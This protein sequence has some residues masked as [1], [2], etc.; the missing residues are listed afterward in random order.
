MAARDKNADLWHGGIVAYTIDG[1]V[2]RLD[3]ISEA[4][5]NYEANTNVRFVRR[6]LHEDYVRF[7]LDA[8]SPYFSDSI[9]RDGGEQTI[10]I[11]ST[12]VG[13]YY[14]EIGH[15]LGLIHEQKRN[16]RDSFVTIHW[17]NI[18]E[19]DHDQ[20]E[21][22]EESANSADYDFR[23][24]MHYP[25][26]KDGVVQ[27]EAVGG[28]PAPGMIGRLAA[29]T[30][31]DYAFL[32]QLYPK[33]GVIRRSSS[34][35]GAGGVSELAAMTWSNTPP[36]PAPNNAR[37]VT[38]V[39]NMS[40]RL[41]L[42]SWDVDYLGGIRRLTDPD[43]DH[44]EAT[45]LRLALVGDHVV[46]CMRNAGGNLYLI[47]WD[48]QLKREADSG[49]M[50]G[51]ARGMQIL[52]LAP[53]AFVTAC[54]D[55][56]GRLLLI[57]WR[58]DG[59]GNFQRVR[60]SGQD[61]PEVKSISLAIAAGSPSQ[62]I[63]TA[64]VQRKSGRVRIYAYSIDTGDLRIEP[65]A[66]SGNSM[67]NATMVNSSRVGPPNDY[68]IVGCATE[69][70]RDLLL[71]PFSVSRDG[72]T[73]TRL[74]GKE[75]KA[76]RIRGLRITP[77]PYGVLT[78]VCTSNGQLLLI[79]WMVAADGLITRHGDSGD[80]AGA[81]IPSNNQQAAPLFDVTAVPIASA[82]VCTPVRN[83]SGDL[84]LITWDDMNGPGELIR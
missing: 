42:I 80:E 48:Q 1:D 76:G 13:A 23:S 79:K 14:H 77:R 59:Q 55:D 67:G 12:Q 35:R 24:I 3:L 20:S 52:P 27:I 74:T 81:L 26:I 7:R 78:V 21:M 44:G 40:H 29:P 33:P 9:G 16:D 56:D 22:V 38:A 18:P 34:E 30:L 19:D 6:H 5:S 41:Q 2:A 57:T 39:R 66:D 61:G 70:D 71:I 49:S 65:R 63:V 73:I 51:E 28:T 32:N 64:T 45:G 8:H 84:L 82:S 69:G 62:P 75:A 4:I 36:P 68:L 60:D 17:S 50:A 58:I 53:D 37:L 47:S 31:I 72:Q 46:G 25:G 83:A 11:S 10:N 43:L 15:A 54:I